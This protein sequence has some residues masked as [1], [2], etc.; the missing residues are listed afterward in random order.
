M[1]KIIH[2]EGEQ[3]ISP[4]NI[5]KHSAG[6]RLSAEESPEGE[7][8]I[9]LDNFNSWLTPK[10][11]CLNSQGQI[12]RLFSRQQNIKPDPFIL[13]PSRGHCLSDGLHLPSG[14]IVKAAS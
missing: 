2:E 12:D 13:Y 5:R 14:K 8:M 7:V 9:D 6:L 10:I 1:A 3:H 4:V 11:G